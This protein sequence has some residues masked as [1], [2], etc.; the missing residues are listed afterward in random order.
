[1]TFTSNYSLIGMHCIVYGYG[2]LPG[3]EDFILHGGKIQDILSPFQYVV[4]CRLFEICQSYDCEIF[5]N[6]FALYNAKEVY[7]LCLLFKNNT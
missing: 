2:E 6:H 5:G 3:D 1:M 4:G 7:R